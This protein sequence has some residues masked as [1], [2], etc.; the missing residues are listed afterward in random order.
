MFFSTLIFVVLVLMFELFTGNKPFF[1]FYLTT[2]Y[3]GVSIVVSFLV[4]N[5]KKA[6]T[7]E[8]A[9]AFSL[10]NGGVFV[11]LAL[12]IPTL[13]PMFVDVAFPVLKVGV[14]KSVAY[15]LTLWLLSSASYLGAIKARRM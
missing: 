10:I 15:I 1:S 9:F 2:L 14:G 4:M 5:F 11:L 12:M 6:L 7:Q 3:A 13:L 8:R